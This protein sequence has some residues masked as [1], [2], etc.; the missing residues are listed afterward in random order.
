MPSLPISLPTPPTAAPASH[1]EPP[2]APRPDL[3]AWHRPTLTEVPLQVTANSSGSG[4]DFNGR[5]LP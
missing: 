4:A 2:A 3:R 5:A 1:L